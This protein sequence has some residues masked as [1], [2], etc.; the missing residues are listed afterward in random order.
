MDAE[1]ELK[2]LQDE[3]DE[4]VVLARETEDELTSRVKVEFLL[5]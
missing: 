4:F 5:V 3:Y 2:I 1:A